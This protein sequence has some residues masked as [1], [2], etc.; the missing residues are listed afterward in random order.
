VELTGPYFHDGSVMTL[1]DVVMLYTRGGNFPAVSPHLDPN[2]AELKNM[3]SGINGN[4]VVNVNGSI[5][6]MVAF[7]KTLTDER[8]RNHSAPF[9]H[10]ELLVPNGDPDFIRIPARDA[11]GNV[12]VTV[13]LTVNPVTSPISKKSVLISGAMDAGSTVQVKLNNDPLVPADLTSATTWSAA[14]TGL[15]EGVN[16]IAVSSVDLTGIPITVST[17]VTV[18]TVKPALTIDPI[19][20]P[21]RGDDTILSGTVEAGI[22]PVVSVSTGATVGA[23]NI[24]G[25]TWSVQLSLLKVGT[26]NITVTATDK[27]G[28][29]TTATA[30]VFMLPDGIFN[31]TRTADVSDAIRALRIAVG[32]ITP[33]AN[34]MLHGDVAP[35]GAPDGR[36]DLV[37]V[38]LIMRNIVGTINLA[39]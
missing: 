10:P 5:D 22:K 4:G 8:V 14:L 13:N 30:S 11:A 26:N 17:T 12:A 1:Q 38:V 15:V 31:G 24:S 32:L 33:T 7:L 3:Q 27:V 20:G 19:A 37:D 29:V 9:D 35:L 39:N 25:T 21:I 36:I 2:I 34:D 28:N 16:N 6:D 18:D 23:P